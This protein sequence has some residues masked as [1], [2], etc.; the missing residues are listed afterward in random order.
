MADLIDA[1][2]PDVPDHNP[3]SD[4]YQ[5]PADMTDQ[6]HHKPAV[7][8][9]IAAVTADLSR[10]GISKDRQNKEQGYRFRGIDDVYNALS[11][12]LARHGLCI[13]PRVRRR[14]ASER[15]TA[16]GKPLFVT[17]VTVDFH[18]VAAA[19]GS[20]HVIR[21]VGEAMDLADKST[22]KAMSAA[23]KYACM[24]A[25]AI[26]T[27]GE[28]QDADERTHQPAPRPQ[29]LSRPAAQQAAN[30]SGHTKEQDISPGPCSGEQIETL[31]NLI[32]ATGTTPAA[33]RAWIGHDL[34]S[35]PA[36]LFARAYAG[37]SKKAAKTKEAA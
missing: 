25:F 5:G 14:E 22:N 17:V 19:D 28:D 27:E 6:Q 13:L 4:L 18:L 21:T 32:D 16:S 20:R 35:L 11:P 9:A 2:S 7:Y 3:D 23:Y 29:Q 15:S 26:P 10:G 12:A 34:E 30:Q 33:F 24:Q 37:L 36:A 8:A 31:R 1:D